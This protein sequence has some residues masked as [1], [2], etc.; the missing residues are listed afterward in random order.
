MGKE[1]V[2]TKEPLRVVY[3]IL[4]NKI[5]MSGVASQ[6]YHAMLE[7]FKYKELLKSH[8]E[9]NG[10]CMLELVDEI[11]EE[12]IYTELVSKMVDALHIAK[13]DVVVR[14]I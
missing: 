9:N 10:W 14:D 6:Q 1:I 13:F 5:F 3:R 12:Q 7:N 4:G 2:A 8:Q 11:S